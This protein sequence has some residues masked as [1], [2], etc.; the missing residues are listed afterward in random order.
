MR[1]LDPFANHGS[2]YAN[3]LSAEQN[4]AYATAFQSLTDAFK[5][6]QLANLTASDEHVQDLVR[7][8]YEFCLQFWTPNKAAYKALAQGYLLPTPYRE[9][10]EAA[11]TG[12]AKYHHDAMV[13]WADANLE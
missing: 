13:I 3:N 5:Q 6:A 7:Q 11:N 10:Y 2:A 4:S 1:E 8:H 12:L 9:A